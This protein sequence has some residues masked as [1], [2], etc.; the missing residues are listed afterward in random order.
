MAILGNAVGSKDLAKAI[1]FAALFVTARLLSGPAVSGTLYQMTSY[2]IMWTI[3]F[4]VL[5]LGIIL[6]LLLIEVLNSESKSMQ[7]GS[8]NDSEETLTFNDDPD[9]EQQTITSPLMARSS[10]END[11]QTLLRVD[12]H[13]SQSQSSY[14]MK[15][16]KPNVYMILLRKHRI[17]TGLIADMVLAMVISSFET[18]IPIHIKQV[19]SWQT[20]QAGLL[21]LLLQLPSLIL[22]V[23][24]GWMKDKFGMHYP[25]VAGFILLAPSLW[26]LGT[27]GDTGFDWANKGNMGQT[28]YLG[29][30]LAIGVWRT[31]ILGFGGVE[32]MRESSE[33]FSNETH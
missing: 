17:L 15:T 7:S 30:L 24:A 32:V 3:P 11:Y 5:A 13:Y 18:T 29:T 19:F 23:P 10:S 8:S 26:L 2:L 4:A 6:Q 28:I 21:F 33:S 22:V 27:P 16:A 1:G 25:V 20:M 31:L 12:E 9:E 14:E